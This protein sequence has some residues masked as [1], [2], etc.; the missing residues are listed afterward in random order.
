[1]HTET[2]VKK[3]AKSKLEDFRTRRKIKRTKT[4]CSQKQ[5]PKASKVLKYA[6][7]ICKTK[8]ITLHTVH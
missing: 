6:V 5:K 1:M 8:H 7:K 3:E 2:T 4:K